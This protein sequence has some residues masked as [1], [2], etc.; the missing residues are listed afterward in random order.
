M[1]NQTVSPSQTTAALAV[2]LPQ[3]W[4][5]SAKLWFAQAEAQFALARITASIT[6]FYHT[7]ASLPDSIA[8]QVD[9]LLEPYG[10]T[11]YEYL[12]AK[13]LERLTTP[14][15]EQFHALIDSHPIGD[16]RPSHIL[17][18][19]R[20]MAAGMLVLKAT[21]TTNMDDLARAADELMITSNSVNAVVGVNVPSEMTELQTLRQEVADLRKQ[22]HR[23]SVTELQQRIPRRR[24]LSPS[25]GRDNRRLTSSSPDGASN[26]SFLVDTG[27][28]V[29]VLPRASQQHSRRRFRGPLFLVA[30]NGAQIATYGTRTINIDLGF[31]KPLQWS[32]LIADVRQ[33]ILGA[34]FFRHFNLLVDVK[35]KQ[36]INAQTYAVAPGT[37]L[38]STATCYTCALRPLNSKSHS[39]LSR[40]PTLITCTTTDGPIRHSVQHRI[41]TFG[42]PVFSRPRRLPPEKLQVAKSEFDTMLRLGIVRPSSSCWASFITYGSQKAGWGV[43]PLW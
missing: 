19:M 9:D 14:V 2:K 3:F 10:D 4:P 22:L 6:K 41:V 42:P 27:S 13:L 43:A 30:A 26:V 15:G 21:Q 17:R 1:D 36:L 25:G 16:Q 8:T 23:L 28:E 7:I 24:S 12:K 18:E 20:R 35:R 11:P 34:D 33:P 37:P 39:I 38:R 32:F 31:E 29:S 5:H 40:Y